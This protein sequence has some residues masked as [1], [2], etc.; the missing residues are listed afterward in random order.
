MTKVTQKKEVTNF[1]K[2]KDGRVIMYFGTPDKPAAVSIQTRVFEA[3][4]QAN[5]RFHTELIYGKKR[6]EVPMTTDEY[7]EEIPK[8]TQLSDMADF[9]TELS[10]HVNEPAIS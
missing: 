7:W 5:N 4:L 8:Q 9:L 3:W 6:T 10:T 2:L 1:Q